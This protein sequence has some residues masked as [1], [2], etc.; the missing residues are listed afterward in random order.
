MAIKHFDDKVAVITGGGSGIGQALACQLAAKGCNLALVDVNR[1]GMQ[2]TKKK[3]AGA[4]GKLTMHVT[5]VSDEASMRA[6]A[7]K[8]IA[9]HGRVSE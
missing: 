7:D 5:D 1:K 9:A 8:V 4:G 3:I 6:L 2:E